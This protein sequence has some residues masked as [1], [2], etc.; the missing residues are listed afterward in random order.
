MNAPARHDGSRGTWW[1][2]L[3]I[4][5]LVLGG[6]QAWTWWR[7]QHAANL[8]KQ[9]ATTGSITMFT[10][11]SCPYCARARAWLTQHEIAWLEC[12]VDTSLSCKAQFDA[13]GAPGVPLMLVNGH[14]HLGFDPAWLAQALQH[15]AKHQ[16]PSSPKADT[17]PR[18]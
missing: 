5:L 18:P 13:Q 4:L 1:S 2:L 7:D 6:N 9:H 15:P 3:L 17:S 14:W 11:S 16:T 12:N 10:T 8:V